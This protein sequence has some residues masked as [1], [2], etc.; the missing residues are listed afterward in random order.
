MT[1]LVVIAKA[2]FG[3]CD[4]VALVFNKV[5]CLKIMACATGRIKTNY[6]IKYS[7]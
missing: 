7:D 1:E 5:N 4:F 3:V 2:T 6:S